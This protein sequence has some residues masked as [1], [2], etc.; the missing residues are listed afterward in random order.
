M[1]SL[2]EKTKVTKAH[3][4]FQGLRTT[5]PWG[6]VVDDMKLKAGDYII[7]EW[8]VVDGK[9]IMTVRKAEK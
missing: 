5:I 8:K 1:Q 6:Y 2:T 4:K 3:T 9:K 7:W